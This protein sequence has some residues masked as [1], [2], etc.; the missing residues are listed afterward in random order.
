MTCREVY[1]SC[2]MHRPVLIP[3]EER[4]LIGEGLG[5]E[6]QRE[7]KWEKNRKNKIRNIRI[8]GIT[9]IM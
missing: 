4:V 1:T 5:E 2:C 9:D 8:K 7:A 3:E 6:E